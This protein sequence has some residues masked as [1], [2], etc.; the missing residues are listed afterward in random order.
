MIAVQ[1]SSWPAAGGRDLCE[2][3]WLLSLYLSS[4][5]YD[6][7]CFPAILCSR[8]IV[9]RGYISTSIYGLQ[10]LANNSSLKRG[11]LRSL[12]RVASWSASQQ[13]AHMQRTKCTLTSTP[14]TPQLEVL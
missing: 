9:P 5:V 3:A 1:A 7:Q 11:T 6:K 8:Y 13:K 2:G 12:H 4:R 10:L 14:V